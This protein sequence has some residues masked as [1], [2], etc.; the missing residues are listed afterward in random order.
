MAEPGTARELYYPEV[1]VKEHVKKSA[2]RVVEVDKAESSYHSFI[3]K[4]VLAMFRLLLVGILMVVGIVLI[5]T[6]SSYISVFHF[7]RAENVSDSTSL[8]QVIQMKEYSR[9]I[10]I[11]DISHSY[12]PVTVKVER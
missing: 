8:S 11:F 4:N 12:Y 10:N 6:L 3:W 2:L 9:S 7:A 5:I 1:Q